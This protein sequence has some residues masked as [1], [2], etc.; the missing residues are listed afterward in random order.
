MPP[1]NVIRLEKDFK[2]ETGSVVF[3]IRI[4]GWLLSASVAHTCFPVR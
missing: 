1:L 4:V 3:E 2:I